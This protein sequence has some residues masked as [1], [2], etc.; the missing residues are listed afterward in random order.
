MRALTS[1][2]LNL[3]LTGL[4]LLLAAYGVSLLLNPEIAWSNPEYIVYSVPGSMDNGLAFTWKDLFKAFDPLTFNDLRPRFLNYLITVINVKFR[5]A[6]YEEFIPSVNLSLMLLVHLVASPLLL[7]LS[8]RNLVK[9]GSI[10]FFAT[11]L[12]LT[13]V[14]FLSAGAFFVQPGKVLIHPMALLLIWALSSMQKRDQGKFFAEHSPRLV[15]LVFILN[16]IALSLDDTYIVVS[17]VACLLFWRLFLPKT[18]TIQQLRRATL[19]GFIFF[20]PFLLYAFFVWKVAPELSEAVGAGRC[21]YFG[22]VLGQ[23]SSL[24]KTPLWPVFRD[25]TTTAIA[26]SFLLRPYPDAM[27]GV[28]LKLTNFQILFV[29]AMLAGIAIFAFL[30]SRKTTASSGWATNPITAPFAALLCYFI[31]QAVL[32]RFHIQITGSYY[33]S[34]LTGIFVSIFASYALASLQPRVSILGRSALL[35]MMTIQLSNF[36]DINQRWKNMHMPLIPYSLS[37]VRD[38]YRNVISDD[39]KTSTL[40]QLQRMEKI[41]KDWKAGIRRDLSAEPNWPGSMAWFL[42]EMNALSGFV[43]RDTVRKCQEPKESK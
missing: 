10:A 4:A 38:V 17:L 28:A 20:L 18:L 22:F 42:V 29:I 1:G 27:S 6:L 25:L 23:S 5:L 12:Y 37:T 14:G 31:F 26:S 21:D 2:V 3:L 9:S 30:G 35:I 19:S 7:F 16:F 33:Y 8:V 39:F 15:A 36:I 41:H 32:Q 40:E 11:C 34:S 13:S 24:T 43:Y